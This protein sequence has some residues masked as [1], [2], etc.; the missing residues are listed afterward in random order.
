MR[1]IDLDF[2]RC[3]KCDTY[4]TKDNFYWNNTLQRYASYCKPCQVEKQEE[5]YATD[6]HFYKA[7]KLL[8]VIK[9]RVQQ[10]NK[11]HLECDLTVEWIQEKLE[12]G[13]E[14]TKLPFNYEG[15]QTWD[16]PSVDRIDNNLGYLQSNCRLV[17]FCVNCFKGTSTDLIMQFVARKILK[18][19]R[20]K[21]DT[22][23]E[24]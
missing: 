11:K 10:P 24:D 6:P 21:N 20:K 2:I 14:V 1:T 8:T 5:K 7:K 13:C 9:Q 3:I 17:L 15:G 23:R 16:S 18:G 22:E 12:K 4:K 19:V